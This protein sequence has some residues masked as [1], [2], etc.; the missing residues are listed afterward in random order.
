MLRLQRTNSENPS[1]QELV[2]LL[3]AELWDRYQD[4]MKEYAPHNTIEN[5]K[6]VVVAYDD[7]NPVGCGCFKSFDGSSVEIKRMY[8]R[9]EHRGQKIGAA[10]LQELERWAKEEGY[11]ATVLETGTKQVEAIR[12]YQ[13][14]GYMLIDK[15]GPYIGMESSVCMKKVL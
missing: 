3:D 2:R 5:N 13:G 6:N 10:L 4:E 14:S 1:F 15:Y 12:L 8:V 9:K 7:N 11:S